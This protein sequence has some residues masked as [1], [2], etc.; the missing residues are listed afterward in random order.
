MNPYIRVDNRL[1]HGQIIAT[2][3]PHLRL[4]RFVVAGD[5]VPA[6]TLQ[7]TM[8]RMAIPGE[9]ELDA[10]TIAD[11]GRFLARRQY[12]EQKTMVLLESVQD[13]VRLFAEAPFGHLNLGNVH[14]GPGRQAVTD[15]VYLGPEDYTA[16]GQLARR[17]VRVEVRSLPSETPIDLTAKLR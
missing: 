8:F 4:Q 16:L 3:M 7:T 2:W 13:A 11:A 14:H 5:G 17:G 10:L 12:G 1:V 9:V 6:N 15:A